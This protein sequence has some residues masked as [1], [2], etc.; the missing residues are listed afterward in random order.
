MP[1]NVTVIALV[2]AEQTEEV[3]MGFVAGNIT[4]ALP[5][6]GGQVVSATEVV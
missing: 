4:F 3:C 5:K 6:E 1:G 2:H